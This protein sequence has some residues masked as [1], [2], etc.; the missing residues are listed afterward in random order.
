MAK[1]DTTGTIYGTMNQTFEQGEKVMIRRIGDGFE[2]R[3]KIVG[4]SGDV[5]GAKTMICE[6]VDSFRANYPYT[7]ITIT[8]VCIDKEEW[9]D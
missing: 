1:K 9:E 8:E 6:M 5:I 3:A 4:L 7:H 2:Y